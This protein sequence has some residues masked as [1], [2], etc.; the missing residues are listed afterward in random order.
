MRSDKILNS[1]VCATSFRLVSGS[2]FIWAINYR[3]NTIEIETG[4]SL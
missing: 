1:T 2:S 4:W 3:L